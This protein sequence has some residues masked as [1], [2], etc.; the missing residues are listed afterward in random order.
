VLHA[1]VGE[2]VRSCGPRTTLSSISD[3]TWRL[4]E[5]PKFMRSV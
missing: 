1:V 4:T 3:L 5:Q 2:E